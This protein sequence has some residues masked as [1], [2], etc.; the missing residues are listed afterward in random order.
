MK[1][2]VLFALASLML[3]TGCSRG[4]DLYQD[5]ENKTSEEDINNN[6]KGVFG[7]DFASN[8]DWCTTTSGELTILADASVSKVQLLVKV[9]EV[10]DDVPSYVTRDAMK[11]LNEAEV[12]GQTTFKMSYDAPKENLGFYVA[13]ITD[14]GNV[15]KKVMG[16]TVSVEESARTRTLSADYVLPS[17]EFRL[18]KAIESYANQRGWVEGEMLYDLSDDD[19]DR[20]KM[21]S[22]DYSD[23]FKTTFRDIVFDIFPNG[24]SHR[25]ID[26]VKE[27]NFFNDKIY[28]ITTGDEPII[29]TPVYKCD[30]P[31]KY[32]YEVWN[33]DLYYYYYKADA[34][35][36]MEDVEAANFFKSLPKYKAIPFG[37]SFGQKEDDVIA[38]HGSFALLYFG[39]G[40]PEVGENGSVGSYMFPKGY[41]I[42]FMIRAKTTADNNKKQ[43]EVY[44]DGRL[45]GHINTDKEFNFS[46]SGLAANDPR[47]AWLNINKKMM[48]TWESG[49]DADFNDI[50]LEIEGG[51]EDIIVPP[52]FVFPQ[53][54]TYCF[55]D[56]ELGDYDMNDVVIK[57]L[58]LNET[59]IEY[60]I[61]ACGAHDE[62]YVKNLNY[63]AI[64]DSKEVHELFGTT[65]QNFVNTQNGD[66]YTFVVGTRTVDK[67]F[68][69][70][71]EPDNEKPYIFNKTKNK[72][73]YLS[74]AGQDP[75]GI[76][77]ACDFLYPLER[78]CIRDAYLQFNN[79]GQNPINSTWWYMSPDQSKVYKN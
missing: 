22:P 20:L 72:N 16:N 47:A 29:V 65:P 37:K 62:L 59:T 69:L 49:T 78:I 60:R 41:K 56:T 3:L 50:I 36:G 64:S 7:V 17:G 38:K 43:G 4:V 1:K 34:V 73:I 6:V 12:K 27:S 2:N 21:T 28:P 15:F 14:K 58:R 67:D 11:L 46:S 44:G 26:L 33:S 71:E 76:M 55:E 61:V 24:R 57:A 53:V 79:W 51:I 19:Y 66:S 63:G 70:S 40:T 13:F 31:T 45:N 9:R 48:L 30:N 39:D 74:K 10:Y 18:A 54:F 77:V 42:G 75:H 25:N 68:K 23:E 52:P 32:G 35:N 8:Q 5:P